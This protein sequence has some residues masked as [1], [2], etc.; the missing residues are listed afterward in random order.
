MYL[1]LELHAI[2]VVGGIVPTKLF[3]T[4]VLFPNPSPFLTIKKFIK[5]PTGVSI[6]LTSYFF[7]LLLLLLCISGEYFHTKYQ[8]RHPPPVLNCSGTQPPLAIYVGMFFLL[9]QENAFVLFCPYIYTNQEAIFM[10]IC[11]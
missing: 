5:V 1:E 7:L 2:K 6:C 4:C 9:G 3:S 11:T 10:Y 8:T